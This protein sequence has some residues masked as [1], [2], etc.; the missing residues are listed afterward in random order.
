M[1]EHVLISYLLPLGPIIYYSQSSKIQMVSQVCKDRCQ[2]LEI[3]G[4]ILF[5]GLVDTITS[6]IVILLPCLTAASFTSNLAKLFQ[7]PFVC[8]CKRKCQ[9]LSCV[10][11]SV[12]HELQ[13]TRLLCPWNSPGKNT[14]QPFPSPGD[15]PGPEIKLI[16]YHLSHQ[17]S[18]TKIPQ[19]YGI[20]H[21][22]SQLPHS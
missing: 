7:L 4:E 18:P 8:K 16:L 17:G 13:P 12:I 21:S 22:S 11:L 20:R 15:F 9:L 6:K 2:L 19:T 1:L 3:R 5:F 10:Q 14:G